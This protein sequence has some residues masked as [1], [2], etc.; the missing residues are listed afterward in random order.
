MSSPLD[1]PVLVCGLGSIGRRHLR[2]LRTLGQEAFVVHRTGKGPPRRPGAEPRPPP[3]WMRE[4]PAEGELEAALG[5]EPAAAVIS[6]PTSLH[7]DTALAAARAGAHLLVEKP[8]SHS[9]DGVEELRRALR[10][11]ELALLVGYQFRFH[12]TLR[13]VRELVR[14][15]AVGRPVSARAWWGEH[16]PG[17]H[18]GEDYTESYA[19]RRDL[20]GG[21][22]L[23]LSH[24]VDYLRWIL[25]PV[26]SVSCRA[27]RLSDLELGVEDVAEI[28]LAFESGAL[29]SVH[30][31]YVRRPPE[32]GLEVV[33]TSGTVAWSTGDGAARSYD[34]ETETWTRHEPPPGLGRNDLF[35][36]EMEHFLACAAGEGEPCCDLEDGVRTLRVALAALES[37]RSGRKVRV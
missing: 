12:P 1:G 3:E 24:P 13:I 10:E 19:A 31:D 28:T 14:E 30:L 21:A 34:P 20:G 32:H 23:T 35:L 33:G 2:N 22:V 16:L 7:V 26:A 27:D 36:A 5:H 11:R 6:N 17:W 18:P 4:L 25:G 9:M 8:L 15:G 29:A 37:A